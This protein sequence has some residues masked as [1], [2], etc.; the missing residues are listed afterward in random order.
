MEEQKNKYVVYGHYYCEQLFYIGSG[1]IYT[2]ED[3]QISRP[4]K[5]QGRSPEWR[6]FCSGEIDKVTVEILFETNDRQEALDIEEHIT[7]MYIDQAPLVNKRYGNHMTEEE[8]KNRSGENSPI[9][10]TNRYWLGKKF[11]EEHK[12]AISKAKKG[13]IFSEEHRRN[14]GLSQVGEKNHQF[15]KVSP[16]AKKVIITNNDTGEQ[17]NFSSIQRAHEFI[18]KEGYTNKYQAFWKTVKKDPFI[19]KHYKI[20]LG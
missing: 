12:R 19:F 4:Y 1:R 6:E 16:V 20:E 11:S 18:T 5:F 9:Y 3:G 13:A 14:M 2:K 7:R 10:G 15:G 17:M 8:K